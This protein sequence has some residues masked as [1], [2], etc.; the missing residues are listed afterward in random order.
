MNLTGS[1]LHLL[2]VFDAV[3]R[4]GGF[5]AA[6]V[7]LGLSQPTISNHITAL[8]QRLGVKLCQR[9][10]RGFLLTEK[11]RM[12]HDIGQTLIGT[13]STQSAQLTALKG[14]LVGQLKVGVVD[15]VT[16]DPAFRLPEVIHAYTCAAPA[17]RV[18]LSVVGL[19]DVLN[20]VL[21]GVLD[22][23]VGT[24][25]SVFS[26]VTITDLYEEKHTIYCSKAHPLF[27]ISPPD[28]ALETLQSFA[29]VHRGYWRRQRR[30]SAG[31]MDH[32]R[33]VHEIEAQL[34]MILSGSYI[35]LLP[36]HLARSFVESGQLRALPHPIEDYT[37]KIQLIT[38]TGRIP[39][40]TQLF[41]DE[42]LKLYA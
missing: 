21:G 22:I 1:D 39:K 34:I 31:A 6:Q 13:L 5:T 8:E 30:K 3:V 40:V 16:T 9:G 41:L 42:V 37:C 32:D 20:G 27:S 7:E 19:Q 29:R 26:G 11:G 15:C 4:H 14:N 38:H 17:V 10:R 23:G 12:V 33:F 35:G 2:T 24:F 28:V 36:D 18:E 25:D